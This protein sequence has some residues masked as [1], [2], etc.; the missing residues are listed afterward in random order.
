MIVSL[1]LAAGTAAA[2][3]PVEQA[4]R[5]FAAMA[6]RDGQWTAFRA[7][8]DPQA[9][10]FVPAPANAQPW[11]AGRADPPTAIVWSPARVFTACD[12]SLAI[13]TGPWTAGKAHGTFTTVWRRQADGSWKWLLDHGRDTPEPI[14]PARQAK[15]SQPNCPSG[16][17][18]AEAPAGL[19]VAGARINP[20]RV[21]AA[22]GSAD[23]LV[24][25]DGAMPARNGAG[26]PSVKI[27]KAIAQGC[28]DDGSLCWESVTIDGAGAGAHDLAVFQRRDGASRLV[29]FDLVGVAA[30]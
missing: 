14:A 7:F 11:L 3:Q 27:G 13:S 28:S 1:L 12:G 23:I 26:L 19:H 10:M 4:E 15:L 5:A 30:P 21:V 25:R 6:Q 9:L 20:A 29:L 17:A 24:Q 2:V 16:P 18:K 22:F 8:A